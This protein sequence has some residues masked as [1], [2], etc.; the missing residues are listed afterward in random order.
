MEGALGIVR[1]DVPGF[2]YHRGMEGRRFLK[3]FFM[4]LIEKKRASNDEDVF[5]HFCKEKTEEGEYYSNEDIA[6]HMVFLML[7]AH[8]TTTSASTMAAYYLA[9]DA[10]VSRVQVRGG[11]VEEEN[12]GIQDQRPCHCHPLLLA[13]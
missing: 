13:P 4:D 10:G 9:H 6:D 2:D 7:A 11:L 1:L 5:A 12:L 8:D 3:R